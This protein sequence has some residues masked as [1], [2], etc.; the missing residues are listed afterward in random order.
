MRLF[1]ISRLQLNP[2][3]VKETMTHGNDGVRSD[4]GPSV[5]PSE[6][7]ASGTIGSV[8]IPVSHLQAGHRARR[9]PSYVVRRY[10]LVWSRGW[11]G[12]TRN[13]LRNSPALG[14]TGIFMAV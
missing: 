12:Q 6:H 7:C 2:V 13:S 4:D 5:K 8:G 11:G 3:H 9:V 10:S 14:D 1:G